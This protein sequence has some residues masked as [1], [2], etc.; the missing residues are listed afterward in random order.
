MT[1]GRTL[2]GVLGVCA[3]LSGIAVAIL[4]SDRSLQ[5]D[6]A[7]ASVASPSESVDLSKLVDAVH[8]SAQYLNRQNDT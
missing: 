2:L 5:V 6:A 3:I 1:T 8:L 4:G 7:D